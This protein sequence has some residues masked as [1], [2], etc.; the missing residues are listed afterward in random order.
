MPLFASA[1]VQIHAT[2]R[3][4]RL[5]GAFVKRVNGFQIA[6]LIEKLARVKERHSRKFLKDVVR[7][8]VESLL[9]FPNELFNLSLDVDLS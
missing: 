6:M 4:N 3:R 5:R 9:P 1:L 7:T 2:E 8:D